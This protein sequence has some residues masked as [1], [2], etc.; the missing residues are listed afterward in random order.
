MSYHYVLELKERLDC[1]KKIAR[2]EVLKSQRKIKSCVI[3]RQS[4]E[5][6]ICY[7]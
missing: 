4:E 6:F 7:N 3:R 2:K 1:T 5:L